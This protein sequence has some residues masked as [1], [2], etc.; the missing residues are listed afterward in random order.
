MTVNIDN[1]IITTP[2]P[3]SET[4]P[5]ALKSPVPLPWLR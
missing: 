2:A 4:N 1:L 5:V 3:K